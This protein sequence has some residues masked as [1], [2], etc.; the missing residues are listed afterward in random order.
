[1]KRFPMRFLMAALLC[2]A[3]APFAWAAPISYTFLDVASL[4]D[5]NFTQLLG[6]NNASNVAGYF[7]DGT[8]VFNNGFR[9][10]LP[11][12]F[13]AENVPHAVQTQV[14][15]I[16]NVGWTD[17][18]FVESTGVTHG[19]TFN[20]SKFKSINAPGTA[21]NQ[22]LAIND[23]LVAAGYSSTDPAGMTLQ[24]AYTESGGTF[25]YLTSFLPS[26]ILNSQAVG[27]NNADT[28][29]G[30]YQ[31]A[32]GIFHGFTLTAAD[33]LTILDFPGAMDTQAAG[34][35]NTGEVTGFYLDSMG[36]MHG[37]TYMGGV[38]QTV[39]NP[40]GVGTTT[41]N[42]VNDNGRLVGFYVNG[43]GQTIGFV[44]TPTS[45][46]EPT[47]FLMLGSG[48]IGMAAVLRRKIKR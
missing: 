34:I 20:G 47:T 13:T 22:L 28:V 14:I 4:G 39:D 6:I 5:L 25:T 41:L 21:F 23:G 2:T 33:V 29:S 24:R 27:I 37:F 32:G 38:W 44:A 11:G 42:G 35:S 19:F 3:I 18:F 17:G 12:S 9:L 30:F 8:V 7:G 31:D 26:G 43:T 16:N 15:G 40:K 46:P 10:T 48:L 1:M 45:V 36:G